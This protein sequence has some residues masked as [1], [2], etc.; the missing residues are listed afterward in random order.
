MKL[1]NGK[2]GFYTNVGLKAKSIARFRKVCSVKTK[3]AIDLF[4]RL[5]EV[6]ALYSPL[7]LNSMVA[8]SKFFQSF[9][10]FDAV[11][12]SFCVGLYP[13]DNKK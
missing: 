12:C 7:G 8:T 2:G 9:F 3:N 4:S 13:K 1:L 10:I 5:K 6:I 11:I